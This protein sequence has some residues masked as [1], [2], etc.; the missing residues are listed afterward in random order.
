MR[1]YQNHF[2]AVVHTIRHVLEKRFAGFEVPGVDDVLDVVLIEN[3]LQRFLD[4]VVVFG[5]VR[6][7]DIIFEI[8]VMIFSAICRRKRM[9]FFVCFVCFF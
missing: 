6:D 9:L 1:H 7:E 5:A 4:P 8:V 3:W 2:A